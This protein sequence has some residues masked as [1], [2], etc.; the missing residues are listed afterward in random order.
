MKKSASPRLS[1]DINLLLEKQCSAKVTTQM[2]SFGVRQ[3]IVRRSANNRSAFD[4]QSFGVRQP[5]GRHVANDWLAR[6]KRLVGT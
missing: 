4:K 3:T 1:R 5:I 2:Q 6:D